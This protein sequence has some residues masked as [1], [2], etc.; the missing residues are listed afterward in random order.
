MDRR[1]FLKSLALLTGGTFVAPAVLAEGLSAAPVAA[2]PLINQKILAADWELYMAEFLEMYR[3]HVNAICPGDIIVTRSGH[4]FGRR[5]TVDSV[6]GDTLT[7]K[8]EA[9]C[10]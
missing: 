2:S 7:F 5:L 3:V 9:F 6:D 10:G 8:N 1:G 4:G